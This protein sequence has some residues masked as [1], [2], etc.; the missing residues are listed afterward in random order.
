MAKRKRLTPAR[1]DYLPEEAAGT[2]IETKSMFPPVLSAPP[3]AQVAGDTALQAAVDN[4]S[5]EI[6]TARAEGR[7]IQQIPLTAIDET[8]LVRDR[9]VVDGDEMSA[10]IESLRARG[11]QTPIE[12]VKLTKD[13]FGL[14]SGWRR[15]T[16]LK[17]LYTETGDERFAI[18]Q[19]LLRRPENASDAYL[20][21]VEE[22][23]IRVGLSYY[24]RA[25]IAAR[26]AEQG[27][28]PDE[29]SAL[30]GL[31]STASR[32]KRSKIGSFIAIYHALD[33][34]LKFA[35]AIPERLGLALSKALKEDRTLGNCIALSLRSNP[36]KTAGTEARLLADLI[37]KVEGDK[38]PEKHT[39]DNSS[40]PAEIIGGIR[41]QHNERGRKLV[42]TGAQMDAAFIDRLKEWLKSQA[43]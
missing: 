7:L 21:M 43:S 1:T 30:R 41:I 40:N 5:S 20:S 38:Q 8:Y 32:A 14:I 23:E 16:A 36:P 10:L 11:Q 4:L 29:A 28:Y 26:A 6:R 24:E 15:L 25:R 34:D 13:Q 37:T 39:S 22:N 3:I 19:A 31:F 9:I 2:A 33:T 18:V 42:L 12:V 35:A 17:A 27:V